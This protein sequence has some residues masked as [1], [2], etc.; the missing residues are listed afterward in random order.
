MR[1]DDRGVTLIEIS[2]AMVISTLVMVAAYDMFATAST[3]T[4]ELSARTSAENSARQALDALMKDARQSSTGRADLP[5]VQTADADAFVFYSPDA[6][7]PAV[8]LRRIE[9]AV[10][11]GT[12]RR[13]TTVS[14]NAVDDPWAGRESW[15]WDVA[16]QW[17]DVVQE[18]VGTTLFTYRDPSGAATNDPHAVQTISVDLVIDPNGSRAPGVQSYALI[19]DIRGPS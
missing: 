1:R 5:R 15:T 3:R 19:I 4:A 11:D 17:V 16:G 8:H 14:V 18:V 9:Y 7:Q 10:V 13:R 6:S 2:I 12:L